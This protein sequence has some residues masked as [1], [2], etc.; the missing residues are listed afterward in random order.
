MSPS[1]PGTTALG[2]YIPLNEIPFAPAVGWDVSPPLNCSVLP[3]CSTE[4]LLMFYPRGV[5]SSLMGEMIKASKALDHLEWK[6]LH[7]HTP[8]VLLMLSKANFSCCWS[9]SSLAFNTSCSLCE[10]W[11]VNTAHVQCGGCILQLSL[12]KPV[13]QTDDPT[14]HIVG[15]AMKWVLCL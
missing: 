12:K 14:H 15:A 11:Q 1:L 6:V 3:L 4:Q 8:L 9:C 13:S 10:T 7:K 5:C 2:N